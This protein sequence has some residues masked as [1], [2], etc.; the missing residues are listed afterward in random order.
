VGESGRERKRC[1]GVAGQNGRKVMVT[2]FLSN[3]FNNNRP[4]QTVVAHQ[5]RRPQRHPSSV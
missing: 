3:F 2:R 5:R 1:S 4:M